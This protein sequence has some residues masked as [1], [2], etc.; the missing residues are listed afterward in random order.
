MM[1]AV[2]ID[3]SSSKITLIELSRS[4]KGITIKNAAGFEI[5]GE[6]I[7]KGELQ[8]PVALSKALKESWRKNKFSGRNIF[9]GLSNLKSIVREVELP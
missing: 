8:D 5:S 7:N 6:S 3:I 1:A 9:V 2:G 4:R